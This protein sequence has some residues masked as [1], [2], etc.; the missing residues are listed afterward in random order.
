M[1]KPLGRRS[2]MRALTM[3]PVALKEAA[4]KIGLEGVLGGHI[5]SGLS[6]GVPP[7]ADGEDGWITKKIKTYWSAKA[8]KERRASAAGWEAR[9][10]DADL[11]ALRSISPSAA[12]T[13]QIDRCVER[14][15]RNGWEELQEKAAERGAR[16]MGIG[17]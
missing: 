10:L 8:A 4:G 16:L 6:S 17:S 1:T 11:A 2:F 5:A 13:I 3:A 15:T 7:Q 14:N 12:Y 9:R